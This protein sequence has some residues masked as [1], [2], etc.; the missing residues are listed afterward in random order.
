MLGIGDKAPA[1]E[2]NDQHGRAVSLDDLLAAGPV[3]LYFY[4]ADFTPL[5][6][7]QACLFRDR[8][9]D[10]AAAGVRVVGIS[11]DAADKHRRFGQKHALNFTLL[12]DPGRKVARAYGATAAWGL[13]PRRVSYCI[14]PDGRVAEVDESNFSLAGHARFIERVLAGPRTVG[15]PGRGGESA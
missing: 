13:L 5:C 11:R 1:F 12:A 6:T 2:L 7:K 8:S 4:P 9:S 15:G 14:A 3:V 10:L